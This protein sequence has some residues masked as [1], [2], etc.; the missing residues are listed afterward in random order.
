MLPLRERLTPKTV[1]SKKETRGDFFV[2]VVFVIAVII[3]SHMSN[4]RRTGLVRKCIR[5][6]NSKGGEDGIWCI[7][8][9]LRQGELHE[10]ISLFHLW[11]QKTDFYSIWWGG[12][13]IWGPHGDYKGE[14]SR[15]KLPFW[16]W[17]VPDSSTS[18]N[19][20]PSST[21]NK[22]KRAAPPDSVTCQPFFSAFFFCQ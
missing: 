15:G 10:L 5:L 11:Y 6:W 18:I 17:H 16:L 9:L 20:I 8:P 7:P 21:P 1:R 19:N 14:K 4:E 22:D 2:V 13:S 12:L 3:G